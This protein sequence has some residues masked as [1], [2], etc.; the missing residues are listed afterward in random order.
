MLRA[1]PSALSARG[2]VSPHYDSIKEEAVQSGLITAAKFEKNVVQK[3]ER[4][5]K[6]KKCRKMK[7]YR[8][9]E[10]CYHFGV[11]AGS[12]LSAKHLHSLFLYTDFTEFCTEF[13]RSFRGKTD[14][15]PIEVVVSRNSKF[16][17]TAKA[18][19]EL[20]TLFGSCGRGMFDVAQQK[21]V[22]GESGPFFCG[23]NCVLNV[24]QFAVSFQCPLST[25]KTKAIALRFAG[26][27]GM[28]MVMNNKGDGCDREMFMNAKWLS[29]FPEEDERLF[30]GSTQWLKV[31]SLTV[32]QSAKTYRVPFGAFSKFDQVLNGQSV[33][34]ITLKEMD[35]VTGAM[36]SVRGKGTASK[37]NKN[38]DQFAVDNFYLMTLQKTNIIL[39]LNCIH[40][41]KNQKMKELVV[42]STLEVK[43]GDI[44]NDTT[45]MVKFDLFALF[46]NLST[47]TIDARF[48]PFSV[49]R[50]LDEL[51]SVDL[52]SSLSTIAIKR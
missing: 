16:Y 21:Y 32:I 44:L 2:W 5:L 50:F 43:G 24:P 10:Q 37:M 34:D 36:D 1:Q 33:E 15:E 19:R 45:N 20:I 18:L 6:S 4:Y 12:P 31:V 35:I 39:Y 38:L 11:A 23:L 29:A 49:P 22:R 42:H 17:Y 41:L 14:D 8:W 26:E 27:R 9:N 3:A 7:S 28:V 48:H 52:P 13:S 25:T 30:M 40:F 47:V 46:P 51:S